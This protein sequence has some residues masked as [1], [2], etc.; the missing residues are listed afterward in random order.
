MLIDIMD[1][2]FLFIIFCIFCTGYVAF[3]QFIGRA[4]QRFNDMNEFV[5]DIKSL[6]S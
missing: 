5:T 2:V 4:R 6:R 3:K 1:L